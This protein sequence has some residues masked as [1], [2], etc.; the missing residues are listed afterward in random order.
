MSRWLLSKALFMTVTFAVKWLSSCSQ[1]NV[2][3]C[4]CQW[5]TFFCII[6]DSKYKLIAFQV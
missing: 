3:S 1:M 2:F 4:L 6:I 5:F